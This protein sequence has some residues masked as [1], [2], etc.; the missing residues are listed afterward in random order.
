MEEAFSSISLLTENT[1]HTFHMKRISHI[2]RKSLLANS[3]KC[4]FFFFSAIF[5]NRPYF[6]EFNNFIKKEIVVSLLQTE[7]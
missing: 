2:F 3:R 6:Y 1:V 7:Y 4:L 5:P